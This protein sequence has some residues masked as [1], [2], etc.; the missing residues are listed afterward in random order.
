MSLSDLAEQP[1]T[2]ASPLPSSPESSLPTSPSTDSVSSLPSVSS[3]F[4]FSSSAATSPPHH[5]SNLQPGSSRQSEH[6]LD[7][8]HG[9]IIPSLTLPDALKR[10]TPFGQTLGD[11]RLLV[12]GAQGAGKSFLTGLLMEDNEDVVEVGTWED[13]DDH[14]GKVLKA[15]T[16]WME[17]KDGLGLERFEPLRNV[18]IVELPGY[19]YDTDINELTRDLKDIIEMPFNSIDEILN[20][21]NQPSAVVANLLSSPSSSLYTALIFLLP[22][23]PTLVDLS[24]IES[25]ESYIPIIV[26]PRISGPHRGPDDLGIQKKR[27]KLSS[28]KPTSAVALKTGL[29]H[30]PETVGLLRG[31]AV[32]RFLRWR[33]VERAVREIKSTGKRKRDSEQRTGTEGWTK[34]QWEME[35]MENHSVHVARRMREGTITQRRSKE[36]TDHL[37]ISTRHYDSESPNLY[38]YNPDNE[39]NEHYQALSPFDPLHLPSLFCL[40]FS[41]FVPLKSRVKQSVKGLWSDWDWKV[42]AMQ[43]A[44]VGGV[45]F[46]LGLGMGLC[47]RNLYL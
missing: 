30:S 9:L 31:E 10:P 47:S 7:Q 5:T 27:F 41:L 38:D 40:S 35:W 12:L 28:F 8:E 21:D 13:S 44:I 1:S 32:D 36:F 11:L 29:F 3:S 37:L 16:D 14:A 22:S 15:S 34:A 18:E 42:S 19:G 23:A 4:F 45:G 6:G 2:H 26:L 24:I 46:C 25:L 33:E 20:P 43:M 39:G 17:V